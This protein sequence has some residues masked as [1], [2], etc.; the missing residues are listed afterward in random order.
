M[1]GEYFVVALF[2]GAGVLLAVIG[3][4]AAGE[5]IEQVRDEF[6]RRQ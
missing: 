2:C 5:I 6:T 3:W 1:N 4:I